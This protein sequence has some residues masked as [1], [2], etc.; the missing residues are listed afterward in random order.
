[1][2]AV[3]VKVGSAAKVV[4]IRHVSQDKAEELARRPGRQV[5]HN[6]V[7]QADKVS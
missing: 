6:V 5:N 4:K 2:N 3:V 7:A 1:V